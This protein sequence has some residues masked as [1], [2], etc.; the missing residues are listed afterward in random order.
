MA[1]AMAC[2]DR[3]YTDKWYVS[4]YKIR[5]GQ[6]L[7]SQSFYLAVAIGSHPFLNSVDDVVL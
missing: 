3:F 5:H 1:L 4:I 6:L 7:W 2:N